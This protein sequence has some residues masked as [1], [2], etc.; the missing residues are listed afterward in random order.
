MPMLGA[1][2]STTQG[3]DWIG[4]A[5]LVFWSLYFIPTGI[6]SFWYFNKTNGASLEQQVKVVAE[7]S[8]LLQD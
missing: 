2:N 7:S 3:A 6:L 1:F 8:S 5:I 4:T